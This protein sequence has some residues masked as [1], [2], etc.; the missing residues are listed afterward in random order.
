MKKRKEEAEENNRNLTLKEEKGK[1]QKGS[2]KE[3]KEKL[4]EAE[5]YYMEI[6]MKA[7]KVL[8]T[9]P[10]GRLSVSHNRG[11]V[12]YL[13]SVHIEGEKGQK[14]EYLRKTK[15]E[16]KLLIRKLAQKGYAQSILKLSEKR[17]SQIQGILKDLT[18][19]ELEDIYGKLNVLR[20]ELIEPFIEPIEVF[21]KRWEGVEY[22]GRI[23]RESDPL[24]LTERGERVLSKSEKILA[25]KFAL[26]G[27]PYR[28]E[29]PLH[30][31][32]Y[33]NIHPD[34][35]L[36][37]KRTREEFYWE[38]L[39]KMDDENYIES[40]IPR[41]EAYERNGIFPG[42]NLILSFESKEKPIDTRVVEK[43]IKLYLM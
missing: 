2:L 35:M 33:G 31:N 36:L 21:V 32:G 40:N 11:K 22:Q 10:E 29:F 37:N 26:M 34:F 19:N 12:R 39:G 27:I 25:D 6:Y 17:I 9:A 24:I 23:F 7:E 20:Q 8:K 5:K 14:E 16:E 15:D 30:L 43:L 3:L 38:H 4:K 42:R 18:N 28:Y 41:L 13:R 1:E